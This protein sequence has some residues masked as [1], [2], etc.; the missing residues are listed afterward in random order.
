VEHLT[1]VRRCRLRRWGLAQPFDGLV[2]RMF[3]QR[4][5]HEIIGPKAQQ[6]VQRDRA[7]FFR[8]QDYMHATFA[9]RGDDARDACQVVFVLAVDCNRDKTQLRRFGLVE[10]QDGVL[11]AEVTPA[12][13]HFGFH[14][15][16]QKVEVCYIA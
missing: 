3:R 11:K 1:R 6:L 10:K 8:N 5:G 9:R 13:A 12:F 7:N 4:V 2:Q 16:D 15:F 14:V